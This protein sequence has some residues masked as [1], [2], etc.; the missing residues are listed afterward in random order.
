MKNLSQFPLDGLILYSLREY[1]NGNEQIADKIFSIFQLKVKE[2]LIEAQDLINSGNNFCA[3]EILNSITK[4]KIAQNEWMY[5]V[6]QKKSNDNINIEEEFNSPLKLCHDIYDEIIKPDE[7]FI[8]SQTK[9]LKNNYDKSKF[10]EV[11]KRA[12]QLIVIYPKVVDFHSFLGLSQIALNKRVHAI[13][14][15]ENALK[16][17]N[18]NATLFSNMAFAQLQA[19]FI[20]HS[21][22][23]YRKAL[24]KNNN[25]FEA[26]KNL[27]K[28]LIDQ[29]NFL[30]AEF[31]LSKAI[32]LKKTCSLSHA[33]ISISFREQGKYKQSIKFA[34]KACELSPGNIKFI[35]NLGLSYKFDNNLDAAELYF[36]TAIKIAP[37]YY[38]A[39]N[40]L[41]TVLQKSNPHEAINY[42]ELAKNDITILSKVYFNLASAYR[43]IDNPSKSHKFIKKSI[44]I[45][46]RSSNSFKVLGILNL[47]KGNFKKAI[48]YFKTSIEINPN[49][50]E[51]YRLL[52][53]IYLF[54]EK[55]ILKIHNL[56][57]EN[58]NSENEQK[59][60]YFTL[61]EAYEKYKEYELSSYYYKKGNSLAY[62]KG[63]FSV[64]KEIR[65][66]ELI[67]NL[68][69]NLISRKIILPKVEKKL[70]FIIGMPRSGST[71]V[72]QILSFN[73]NLYTC[74]E[75]D[76]IPKKIDDFLNL[77]IG[78]D[79]HLNIDSF[80]FLNNLRNNYLGYLD[81]ITKK[82]IIVDKMPYNFKYLG[83]INLLFPE[84]KFIHVQR[85]YNDNCFSIYK[86]YFSD[87][88][89]GY[90]YKLSD[91]YNYFKL[92]K[93][94]ME[95]WKN[96]IDSEI[97]DLHYEKLINDSKLEIKNL[98]KFCD[99]NWNDNY[100]LFYKNKR[101]VYTASSGQVRQKLY[102]TSINSWINFAKFF[103]V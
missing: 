10:S 2:K 16:F 36:R 30:E 24:I 5:L 99:F 68:Y 42:Y 85:N 55:E 4:A 62:K 73:K 91:T 58:N 7:N 54:K 74:G 13:K 61:G 17:T 19:G 59:H 72:E 47:D 27:G 100:L 64:K 44:E 3:D 21:E 45:D 97:Y 48:K 80:E 51:V 96:I 92:Y 23:F 69:Y 76:F 39:H 78:K 26:N 70:V 12:K 60:F 57:K 49:N 37:N 22:L 40:N 56:L 88:S 67:K 102:S 83:I 90:S 89:H 75:L 35:N 86:N 25:L 28:I 95:F 87:N 101:Q 93:K 6:T 14:T 33:N 9:K 31:Y 77:S 11:V 18:N 71:L 29:K 8:I 52:G 65:Y 20:E 63:C 98:I 32:F 46:P 84:A 1:S 94:Q 15:F 34:I 43:D 53:K 50:A 103:K 38:E 82:E 79:L 81:K 41:G 66:H